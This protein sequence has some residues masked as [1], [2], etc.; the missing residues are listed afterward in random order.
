MDHDNFFTLLD[1]FKIYY[2]NKIISIILDDIKSIIN[3]IKNDIIPSDSSISNLQD[4]ISQLETL[5]LGFD[6]IKQVIDDL[7]K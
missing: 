6:Y 4:N 3:N 7:N 5:L 2:R 1:N